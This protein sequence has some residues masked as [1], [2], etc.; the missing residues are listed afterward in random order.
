[1]ARKFG[2]TGVIQKMKFVKTALVIA[3]VILI[4]SPLAQLLRTQQPWNCFQLTYDESFYLQATYNW[5][6]GNGY[7]I[8]ENNKPF[9]PQITVGLPL[10]IGISAVKKM[11]NLDWPQAGRLFVHLNFYLLLL[12]IGF[13]SL[14]KARDWGVPLIA[15]AL[16]GYLISKTPAG[17]YLTYGILGEIPAAVLSWISLLTLNTAFLPF[18]GVFAVLAYFIKPSYALIIPVIC[19]VAFMTDRKKGLLTVGITAV[20]GMAL[21]VFIALSRQETITEYLRVLST[22]A[23]GISPGGTFERSMVF[24]KSLGVVSVIASI[25][26]LALGALD[27]GKRFRKASN[28]SPAELGAWLFFICGL[29]Y[30]LVLGRDP[31]PKH[32]FV[33]YN[34]AAAL[35][36]IRV[37]IYFGPMLSIVFSS[38]TVKI[39]F[40]TCTL[41]WLINVPPLLKQSFSKA[42]TIGCPV[43]E[44]RLLDKTLLGLKQEAR[45]NPENFAVIVDD[46][47]THFLYELGFNPL[48]V[49]NWGEL[50]SPRTYIAGDLNS[51]S[52]WPPNCTS[53]WK[54]NYL[55]L[56]ECQKKPN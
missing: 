16:L 2:R 26:V 28:F 41:T 45:L 37:S 34:I 13:W 54:G 8:H 12:I 52:P 18:S 7:K 51:L 21:L 48:Y 3:S 6:N 17:G 11:T 5:N 9:E 14:K 25:L 46:A 15:I 29:F 1:M 38:E 42:S 40:L 50:G 39:V 49:R 33:F 4:L 35:L 44:Q 10:A 53:K 22:A 47:S 36:A 56:L 32:W 23:A 19:L 43:K 27:F 31:Q 55:A 24:F 20:T 30:Y